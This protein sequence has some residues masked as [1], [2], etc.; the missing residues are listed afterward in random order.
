LSNHI[1]DLL[2]EATG[3]VVGLSEKGKYNYALFSV[4]VHG[5]PYVSESQ[6]TQ[7]AVSVPEKKRTTH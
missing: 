5:F 3:P 6:L 2:N 7:R 4:P 1:E